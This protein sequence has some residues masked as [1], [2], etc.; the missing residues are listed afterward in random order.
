MY[1][2]DAFRDL[3]PFVQFRNV[4]NTHGEVLT[5]TKVLGYLQL[6]EK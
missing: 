3:V 6:K 2:C 4:K 5:F 1:I